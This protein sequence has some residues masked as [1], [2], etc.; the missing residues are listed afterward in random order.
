M[1]PAR[2]DSQPARARPREAARLIEEPGRVQTDVWADSLPTSVV[3]SSWRH[4]PSTRINTSFVL[5]NDLLLTFDDDELPGIALGGLFGRGG[6]RGARWRR[7]RVADRRQRGAAGAADEKAVWSPLV[8][9]DLSLVR[10]VRV[11]ARPA[12]AWC[13]RR[14]SHGSSTRAPPGP[15]TTCCWTLECRRT[16]RS[17][18]G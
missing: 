18:S 6:R 15:R 9:G 11:A 5:S 4:C 7:G 1:R 3:A 17:P 13:R 14:R 8:S 16:A 2:L 12:R 10:P